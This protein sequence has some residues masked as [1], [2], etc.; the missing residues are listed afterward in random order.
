[1]MKTSRTNGCASQTGLFP[2]RA[3]AISA[4]SF[5]AICIAV[6]SPVGVRAESISG[7]LAKAY[8]FSP[9]LN[10]QRAATRATDENVP[11]ATAGF[12]PMV[13]ASGQAG[14]SRTELESHG[15]S[16][17]QNTLPRTAALTVTQTLYNGN[18]TAN[19]L[20]RAESQ[21]FQSRENLRLSEQS[22][23]GNAAQAYMNVLRDTALLKLQQN[24]VEVLQQQLKQTQDRFQVGEV[25]RTDVAQAEAALAQ[26]QANSFTSQSNLQTSLAVYRQLIGEPPRNLEPARPLEGLLPK[27][28]QNAVALS[29]AEHPS[30]QAALHAVDAAALQVKIQEG[31][32]YPTLSVQGSLSQSRDASSSNAGVSATTATALAN[33]SVPIYDGGLSYAGIRQAKETLSQQRLVA[34]QQREAVR[35]SVVSAWGA[36]QNT[37]F[38]IQSYESQVRANEIALNGVREEAKVGQRTTLDVLNAQQV[39]LNSRVNLISAQRDRVVNSYLLLSSIGKLSASI[40]GLG[41]TT[42]DPTVHYDQVKDK[43]W[44]VRTPDGR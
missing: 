41:V 40:L 23:L 34:D 33:L 12:R 25:T 20:R 37:R 4:V 22:I 39:L 36:Y 18:R 28:L 42:Y 16:A 14:I 31:T 30:I 26:G 1:M 11:A 38:V 9:D 44:G 7:A 24:N 10:Q 15:Q 43:W 29:Q 35:A 27:S 5:L 2:G 19:G 8:S 13:S 3:G 17:A 21:V 32:L 6:L